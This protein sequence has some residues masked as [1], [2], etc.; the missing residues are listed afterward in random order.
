MVRTSTLLPRGM[1]R[2]MYRS[3]AS[4]AATSAPVSTV[5]TNVGGSAVRRSA[6]WIAH[7]SAAAVR[8]D[9]L[10]PFRIATLPEPGIVNVG[11]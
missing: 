11:Q 9:S 4:N 10:P 5:C 7:A 3:C 6:A 2:S 8:A 1:T